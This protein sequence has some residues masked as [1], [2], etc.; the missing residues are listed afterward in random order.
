MKAQ[1]NM[2]YEYLSRASSIAAASDAI[3]SAVAL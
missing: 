1:F 2:Q 3:F